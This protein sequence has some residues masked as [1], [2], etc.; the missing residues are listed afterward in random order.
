MKPIA[1]WPWEFATE[2]DPSRDGG[3]FLVNDG[4]ADHRGRYGP[5][6]IRVIASIGLDWDHVSV[7]L[8][9]R[10]PTW[11]E[12]EYVRS[13][14]FEDHEC[15]VQYSAPRAKHINNH[16]YCLHLWRPQRA[17]IPMPPMICV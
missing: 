15:A 4:Q 9:M 1:Q 10:C 16:P 8:S 5:R 7:S 14:F 17:E 12:M 2:G 6:K 11:R 3:A 13:L